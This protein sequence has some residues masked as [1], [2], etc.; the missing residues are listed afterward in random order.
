MKR[1]NA[2]A[3]S[4]VGPQF[5][6][7]YVTRPLHQVIK[8]TGGKI[9]LILVAAERPRLALF[10]K[11]FD[12]LSGHE[13]YV[14]ALHLGR[15]WLGAHFFQPVTRSAENSEAGEITDVLSANSLPPEPGS[16]ST[17]TS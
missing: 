7:H 10:S 1:L 2:I 9:D 17:T 8:R 5:I 4:S 14:A 3:H 12:P 13:P 6:I 11:W 15:E 16:C